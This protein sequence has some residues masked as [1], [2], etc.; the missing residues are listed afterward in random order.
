MNRSLANAFTK[1]NH[2]PAVQQLI[3]DIKNY[4]SLLKKLGIE[5]YQVLKADRRPMRD[6]LQ[7]GY[8]L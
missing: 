2:F 5:D 4:R 8:R 1:Y 3:S 7:I 6:I